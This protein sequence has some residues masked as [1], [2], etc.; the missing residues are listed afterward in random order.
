MKTEMNNRDLEEEIKSLKKKVSILE[1]KAS[2]YDIL[3]V[4]IGKYYM[5]DGNEPEVK[6][7]LCDIGEVAA[8]HFGYL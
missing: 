6:G 4:K 8:S 5:D 7:D 2:S 1:I 3:D